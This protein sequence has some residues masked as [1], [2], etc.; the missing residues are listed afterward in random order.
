MH[1]LVRDLGRDG[2]GRLVRLVF[3]ADALARSATSLGDVGHV[4]GR[5]GCFEGASRELRGSLLSSGIGGTV[6]GALKSK[7]RRSYSNNEWIF[8]LVQYADEW[9][10]SEEEVAVDR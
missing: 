2:R 9:S 4:Y 10:L 7:E 6:C 3:G 8:R 1:I 5:G